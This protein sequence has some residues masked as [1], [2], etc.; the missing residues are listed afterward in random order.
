MSRNALYHAAAWTGYC[1]IVTS[2]GG[3]SEEEMGRLE[4][5]VGERACGACRLACR[6][7]R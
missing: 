3:R 2:I 6:G 7:C 5:Q 1:G 4:G